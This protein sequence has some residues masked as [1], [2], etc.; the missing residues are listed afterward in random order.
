MYMV[1]GKHYKE[2]CNVLYDYRNEN[3]K[4]EA[5]VSRIIIRESDSF[6]RRYINIIL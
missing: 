3:I 1:P 5:V 2:E 6:T 4:N